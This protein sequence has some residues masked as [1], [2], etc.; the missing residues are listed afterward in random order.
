MKNWTDK[1]EEIMNVELPT[2]YNS[3]YSP[4]PHSVFIEELKEQL[5]KQGMVIESKKYLT[6]NKGL[7]MTGEYGIKTTLDDSTQIAV[8]FHNSYNKQMKAGI[9]GGMLE[10]W[11]SNGA[12]SSN[13]VSYVRK[14]T[15]TALADVREQMIKVIEGAENGYITLLEEREA[16]KRKELSKQTI[17]TLIGDMY[18]N[19]ALINTTQLE[20]IKREMKYNE[21]FSD[22]TAFSFLNWTTEA[23]KS[24]HASNYIKNHLQIYTY[25]TN[26]LNLSATRKNVYGTLQETQE[27]QLV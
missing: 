19:E 9:Y 5:D 12:Y 21:H 22:R 25:I 2:Q 24:S 6:A 27:L 11:C 4:I 7:I 16:M 8:G 1:E 20:I 14:H 15:G 3:S 26:K 18:I 10:L 23:L 13:Q 17:A